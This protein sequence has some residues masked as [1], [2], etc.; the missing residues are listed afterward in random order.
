MYNIQNIDMN[1]HIKFLDV[2][3]RYMLKE[4]SQLQQ[5]SQNILNHKEIHKQSLPKSKK[6]IKKSPMFCLCVTTEI[7]HKVKRS[8]KVPRNFYVI[9]E[10]F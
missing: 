1:S 10:C 7:Y 2:S 6:Q 3:V 4:K 9:N 8:E 5:W